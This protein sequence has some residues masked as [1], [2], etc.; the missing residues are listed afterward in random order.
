MKSRTCPNTS[1]SR[2]RF[3]ALEH[4]SD[5][6]K[7]LL[8]VNQYFYGSAHEQDIPCFIYRHDRKR[9]DSTDAN[10]GGNEKVSEKG[11]TFLKRNALISKLLS[12]Q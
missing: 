1:K 10:L 7:I 11:D 2:D 6:I 5:S 8:F 4:L 3:L 12:V 9:P